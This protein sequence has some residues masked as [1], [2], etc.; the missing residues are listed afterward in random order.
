MAREIRINTLSDEFGQCALVLKYSECG[1]ERTAEPHTFGRVATGYGNGRSPWGDSESHLWVAVAGRGHDT[2]TV[3]PDGETTEVW[4]RGTEIPE[5]L[6]ECSKWLSRID[7]R[8]ICGNKVDF[9]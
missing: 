6:W 5:A 1:H 9:G 8:A 7:S 2:R 3:R 4:A